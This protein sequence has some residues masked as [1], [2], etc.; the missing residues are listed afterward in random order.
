MAGSDVVG[1]MNVG[2]RNE[3]IF[4]GRE[5]IERRAVSEQMS[6]LVDEEVRNLLDDA[7]QQASSVISEHQ[8]SLHVLANTLLERETLDSEEIGLVF[9]GKELPPLPEAKPVEAEPPDVKTP[10]VK[11]TVRDTAGA[12]IENLKPATSFESTKGE[13]GKS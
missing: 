13:V 12:R 2:D 10:E 1:P 4:L 11:P 9:E 3:E 6:R 5:I 8:E 7:F